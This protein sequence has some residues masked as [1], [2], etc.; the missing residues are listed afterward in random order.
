MNF[1]EARFESGFPQGSCL[2]ESHLVSRKEPPAEGVAPLVT[3][4]DSRKKL[5]ICAWHS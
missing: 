2:G 3:K 5:R 1:A 4:G